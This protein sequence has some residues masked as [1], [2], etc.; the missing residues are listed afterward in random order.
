MTTATATPTQTKNETKVGEA[1]A[2]TRAVIEY[3]GWGCDCPSSAYLAHIVNAT[4]EFLERQPDGYKRSKKEVA[5]SHWQMLAIWFA[6][7]REDL[8]D[9][10]LN[11]KPFCWQDLGFPKGIAESVQKAIVHVEEELPTKE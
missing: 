9:N 2:T 8:Q 1:F 7:G 4:H 5:L 6:G 10:L 11:N 3:F